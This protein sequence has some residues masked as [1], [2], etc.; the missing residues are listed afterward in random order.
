MVRGPGKIPAM[1]VTGDGTARRIPW[2]MKV[3]GRYNG[4]R[5][6]ARE[7]PGP[8]RADDNTVADFRRRARAGDEQAA[9][10]VRR[11]QS[12]VRIEVRMRLAE[13]RRRQPARAL[14]RVAAQIGL[15]GRADA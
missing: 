7:T 13:S 2:H 12:A 6:S 4:C 8:A 14:D 9:E 15:E 11:Y 3:L 10:L 5:S 1:D